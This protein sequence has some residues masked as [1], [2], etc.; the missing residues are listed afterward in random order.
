[1]GKK[2]RY[3]A[4]VSF[5][6][7]YVEVDGINLITSFGCDYNLCSYKFISS[8]QPSQKLNKSYEKDVF[9]GGKG[10]NSTREQLSLK[11]T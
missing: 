6:L 9:G 7:Y 3:Q 2:Y 4:M 11:D 5:C 10:G 8:H 1:V